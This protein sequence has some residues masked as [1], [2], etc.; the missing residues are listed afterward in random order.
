MLPLLKKSTSS[1]KFLIR[2]IPLP[3]VLKITDNCDGNQKITLKETPQT[4]LLLTTVITP[5][6]VVNLCDTAE[7]EV[8]GTNVQLG[9][10]YNLT[11]SVNV[12]LGVNI[13]PGSSQ[14]AYPVA[15][16]YVTVSDPVYIGGTIYQYNISVLSP[17]IGL[18]GMPGILN[19]GD[20][21]VKIK[22][23]VLTSC[24][25]TSGSLASFSFFGVSG[26]GGSTGNSFGHGYARHRRF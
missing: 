13:V 1:A 7:Y 22:F 3:P 15:S 25:Y 18:N 21:A 8:I 11:V 2:K 4:P 9:S 14:L 16:P 5:P 10:V 24:G 20:N 6:T 17:S 26:C 23:K 19:V 12:P